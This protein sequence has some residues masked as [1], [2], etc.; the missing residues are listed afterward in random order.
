MNIDIILIGC[1]GT[2][3]CFF[4]RLV[5]FLADTSIPDTKISTRIMDGDIVEYKNIG[6]QPF[7]EN[8]IGKNKAVALASAA[9]ESFNILI[10]SYPKYLSQDTCKI[11]DPLF[12]AWSYNNIQFIIGAVDN[13]ACRRLLHQYFSECKYSLNTLFYIDSANEFSC[14]EI[15]IAKRSKNIIFAP[16]RAHYYPEILTDQSKPIYEMSCEELNQ[17]APQHLATNSLAADLMFSYLAQVI[18]A[19]KYAAEAP[20]GIIYFDAFKLF[21]RFDLYDEVRHGKIK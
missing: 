3:G 15:V 14:G 11:L 7:L 16:D 20:G 6:R 12:D 4:S 5:R 18:N 8:D 1:G 9:E 10:K 19:G 13:H 21:S 2:G 17:T